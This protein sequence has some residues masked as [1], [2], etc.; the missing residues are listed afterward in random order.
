MF[1]YVWIKLDLRTPHLSYQN[2]F[3]F[4]LRPETD[5]KR[6]SQSIC[7]TL[8]A[9]LQLIAANLCTFETQEPSKLLLTIVSLVSQTLHL[10]YSSMLL[11]QC[12]SPLLATTFHRCS[13]RFFLSPNRT[14][15]SRK[16]LS[17]SKQRLGISKRQENPPSNDLTLP[18]ISFGLFN[19]V[20][21]LKGLLMWSF[22]YWQQS[23]W[24]FTGLSVGRWCERA[25][26]ANLERLFLIFLELNWFWIWISELSSHSKLG[27][28]FILLIHIGNFIVSTCLWPLIRKFFISTPN[29]NQN[30][31]NPV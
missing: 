10:Y 17:A 25:N 1:R 30:C 22:F 29:R 26:R 15:P 18:F 31:P 6:R 21:L 19:K 20:P 14:P 2:G 27:N 3:Y 23:K 8:F 7:N 9:V 12:F 13:P 5:F 11:H 24:K 28:R 16:W 4:S